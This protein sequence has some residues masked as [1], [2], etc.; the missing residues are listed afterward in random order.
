MGIAAIAFS[1]SACQ[2]EDIPQR[3]MPSLDNQTEYKLIST[4]VAFAPGVIGKFDNFV[5]CEKGITQY[6]HELDKRM[7]RE[8]SSKPSSKAL[9]FLSCKPIK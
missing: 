5:S 6:A 1:A 3:N 9:A 2:A 4:E 7:G 8:P